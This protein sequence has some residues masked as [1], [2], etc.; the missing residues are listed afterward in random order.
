MEIKA[1]L[2]GK[3][4]LI[5]Q[6]QAVMDSRAEIFRKMILTIQKDLI[7]DQKRQ[8]SLQAMIDNVNA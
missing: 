1:H 7:H 4:S 5:E 8:H 6:R 3:L 2:E